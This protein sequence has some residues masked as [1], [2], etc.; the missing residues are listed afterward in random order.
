MP[1]VSLA[2]TL[3]AE[4]RSA[5]QDPTTTPA[6]G[7]LDAEQ[8]RVWDRVA[9][10]AE[11]ELATMIRQ[12]VIA[13]PMPCAGCGRDTNPLN[14]H[15]RDSSQ[16]CICRG[17]DICECGHERDDHPRGICWTVGCGCS[18]FALNARAE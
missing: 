17:G 15:E 16:A 18:K 3:Y 8:R 4:F 10:K 5:Q 14:Q 12:P 11:A 1:T 7:N 2:S 13:V 6:Y 9:A